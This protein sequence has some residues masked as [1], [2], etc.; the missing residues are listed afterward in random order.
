MS[1]MLPAYLPRYLPIM[2][3]SISQ[4]VMSI[5][6]GAVHISMA[7]DINEGYENSRSEILERGKL[8]VLRNPLSVYAVNR[9]LR[10][11]PHPRRRISASTP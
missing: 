11:S 6:L 3:G 2:A 4:E 10:T 5:F 9:I 7:H 8:K 1:E